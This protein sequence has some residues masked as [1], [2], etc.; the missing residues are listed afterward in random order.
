MNYKIR[1]ETLTHK[2]SKFQR[3]LKIDYISHT[4][5]LIEKTC[6]AKDI[7]SFHS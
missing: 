1:H 2:V 5:Q 4:I 6:L 7:K 3:F